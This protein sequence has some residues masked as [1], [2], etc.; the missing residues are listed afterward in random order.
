MTP[1]KFTLLAVAVLF[2]TARAGAQRLKITEGN[3]DVLKNETKINMEFTYEKLSVGKY[4]DESDYIAKKTDE[5]NKK[6]PGRGD[7]W[8]KEWIADRKNR[9][10]PQFKELFEKYSDMK[11]TDGDKSVKYTLVLKTTTMEPGFNV[12]VM[13]KN[14]EIDGEIWIVETATQNVVCEIKMD[15]AKGRDFWGADFDTGG[16]IAECYADA[17]KA[18]AKFIKKKAD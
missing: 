9:Y 15:N 2:C 6:E 14:A 11:V 3:L 16:R 1:I 18:V 13:R 5:Y 10:E 12:G 17:G 7:R 4:K 8:A